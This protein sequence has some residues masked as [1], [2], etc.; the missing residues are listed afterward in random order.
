MTCGMVKEG[1]LEIPDE[2][3]SAFRAEMVALIRTRSL[4]FREF[5]ACRA[6]DYHEVRD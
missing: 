4:T 1:I 3:L 6:L 5:G 2:R